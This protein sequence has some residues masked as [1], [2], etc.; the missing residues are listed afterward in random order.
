MALR[1]RYVKRLSDIK[2]AE[3]MSKGSGKY[4]MISEATGE[5]LDIYKHKGIAV[6]FRNRYTGNICYE[7]YDSMGRFIRRGTFGD[8]A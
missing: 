8:E 7:D 5:T 2:I 4:I 1:R 6:I 3:I